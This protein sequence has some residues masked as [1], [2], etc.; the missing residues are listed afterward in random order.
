MDLLTVVSHE[1][2]HTLGLEDIDASSG[3]LMSETLERGLRRE[4]GIAE[5]DA[6]FARF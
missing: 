3:S 1:L 6:L 5:I 4:P 2:G